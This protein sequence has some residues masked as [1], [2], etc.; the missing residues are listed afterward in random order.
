MGRVQVTDTDDAAAPIGQLTTNE[1]NEMMIIVCTSFEYESE[2]D[3]ED[4][5]EKTW[6]TVGERERRT[7]ALISPIDVKCVCVCTT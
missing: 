2:G 6:C 4:N 7:A 5:G 1:A 3:E